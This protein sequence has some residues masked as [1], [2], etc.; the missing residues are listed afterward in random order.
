MLDHG[1]VNPLVPLAMFDYQHLF[2]LAGG[3]NLP[4]VRKVPEQLGPRGPQV[5]T[6]SFL[7]AGTANL[8]A[9]AIATGSAADVGCGSDANCEGK[10][11]DELHCDR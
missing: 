5:T 7:D 2:I 10:D 11:C 6:I 1:C 4:V 8:V 3:V 9:A